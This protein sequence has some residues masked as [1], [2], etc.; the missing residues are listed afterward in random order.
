[1][2]AG[3]KLKLCPVPTAPT[4][5]RPSLS[6]Y[7]RIS[8]PS[9]RKEL[10]PM[11]PATSRRQPTSSLTVPLPRST[12]ST[13]TRKTSTRRRFAVCAPWVVTSGV[14]E[15]SYVSPCI[16]CCCQLWLELPLTGAYLSVDSRMDAASARRPIPSPS[17]RH[18]PS[19]A[20]H[21]SAHDPPAQDGPARL[22][23]APPCARRHSPLQQ[24]HIE[25]DQRS[26]LGGCQSHC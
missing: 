4:C 13:A 23:P 6:P 20:G 16:G 9:S 14:S 25:V 10:A 8:C 17:F 18:S 19:T 3:T 24:A 2:P 15:F 12:S 11:A 21:S 26:H 22:Q 1:M 7:R 5:V